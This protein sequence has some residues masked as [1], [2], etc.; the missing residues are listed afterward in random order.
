MSNQKGGGRRRRTAGAMTDINMTPMIDVMLVL[1]IVFMVTAPMMT[2]GVPVDLPKTDAQTQ[3]SDDSEPLVITIDKSDK[4][5]LQETAVEPDVLIEKLKAITAQK[6]DQRIFI[7]GDHTLNYGKVM[8]LMG[9][10]TAAGFNRVALV[11]ETNP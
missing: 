11:A 10:L 9:K 2:V 8:A 1:L 7:R 3:S 4:I 5:Y 6:P